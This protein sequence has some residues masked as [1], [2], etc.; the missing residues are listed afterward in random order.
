MQVNT[1]KYTNHMSQSD[2]W[3]ALHYSQAVLYQ[4]NE[5]VIAKGPY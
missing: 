4:G 2:I 5:Q 3:E 1:H